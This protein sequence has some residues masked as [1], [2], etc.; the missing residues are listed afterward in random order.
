MKSEQLIAKKATL[1]LPEVEKLKKVNPNLILVFGSVD[2]FSA[3]E[4]GQFLKEQFPK[5]TIIGCSTAG[6]ISDKGVAD[7]SLVVTAMQFDKLDSKSAYHPI[8]NGEDS[9]QCGKDLAAKLKAP[10]LK[11]VF[12]LGRG[13]DINGTA[14]V[15]GMRSVFGDKVVITGGLAGDGGAFKK[16]YTYLNGASYDD[17]VVAVGFY[18][19]GVK[20]GYG[21]VGGWKPFGDTYTVTKSQNNVMWEIDGK[22]ALDLYKKYL[23]EEAKNLPGSGLRFPFALLDKD[24]N[25]TGIVRTILDVNEKDGTLTFAGDIP[26]GARVRLMQAQNTNLVDGA[27]QAASQSVKDDKQHSNGVGILVSCVGRKIVMGDD[28]DNEV[29]AVREVLGDNNHITGF[30]SYG[31]IC[32]ISGFTECKL[33]NQTMTITWFSDAA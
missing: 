28:I 12:V 25:Q 21:S 22:R 1:G 3:K 5:A 10:N 14:L 2:F 18:G 17:H 11:T 6:E 19:E 8:K 27:R 20:V 4:K 23:G 7:N 15:D 32:P 33:H 29:D 9:A 26:Q 16:T 13:L 30:Y 24:Q 31:E